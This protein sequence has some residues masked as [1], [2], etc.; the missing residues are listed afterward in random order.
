MGDLP[1]VLVV[2]DNRMLQER[3]AERLEGKVTVLSAHTVEEARHLFAANPDVRVIALDGYLRPA[4]GDPRPP[5]TLPLVSE[6]RQ[7]FRGKIIAMA[8]FP[9]HRQ[10]LVAAGCDH[11]CDKEN[12]PQE[13]ELLLGC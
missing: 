4:F 12:L 11:S 13:I 9:H 2:E 1:K 10:A 7:T 3:F 6:F 5:D 8:F